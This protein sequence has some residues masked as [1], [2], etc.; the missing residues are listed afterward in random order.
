MKFQYEK[1]P[2]YLHAAVK[3]LL[4]EGGYSDHPLDRGGKTYMGITRKNHADWEGWKYLD[5][6]GDG[7]DMEFMRG[8]ALAFYYEKYWK[9]SRC[10]FVAQYS[11]GMA[12]ELF[13][14]AVHHG[15]QRAIKFLQ[16][17]LNKLNRNG[18]LFSDF[19]ELG[20]F[21]RNGLTE[22]AVK[23]LPP[24]D[25]EHA[26][27]LMKAHRVSFMLEFV[28]KNPSQEAFIR[29]WMKRVLG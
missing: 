24:Q 3:T 8:H 19:P 26:I 9:E 7:V 16:Q 20:Y 2:N 23:N 12:N 13:D 10:D 4:H 27:R 11:K 17:S 29:G 1:D 6:H 5:E 22:A 28:A 25:W 18:K 21:P 15:K 14:A